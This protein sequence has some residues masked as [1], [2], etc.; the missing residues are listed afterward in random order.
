MLVYYNKGQLN[1]DKFDDESIS[2][3]SAMSHVQVA[4]DLP[5]WVDTKIIPNLLADETEF[6]QLG[7]AEEVEFQTLKLN[8]SFLPS[9]MTIWPDKLDG[10]VDLYYKVSSA[11]ITIG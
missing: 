2:Y 7:N 6:I 8:D 4:S 10:S 3:S 9:S 1:V 5:S 11:Y